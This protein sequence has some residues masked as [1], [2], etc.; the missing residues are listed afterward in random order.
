MTLRTMVAVFIG[1]ALCLQPSAGAGKETVLFPFD[2]YSVPFSKGL[3]LE[4]VPG[5]KSAVNTGHGTDPLHPSKPVVPPG[6]PG[7]PDHPRVYYYGTVL[8]IDGE[9]RMWYS[10]WDKDRKRQVLYAVSRDGVRWDKPDLGLV[11]YN[12]NRRNN[13]V[14]SNGEGPMQGVFV[15]VLHEP[16][17]PDPGRRFKMVREEHPRAIMAAYSPDGLSWTDS[18]NNPIIKGS[19]M[20]T[21]GL[22][23]FNGFY[24]LNGQGGP[25]P[26][27]VPKARGRKMVTYIS[28]DFDHWSEAAHL[29][30]RRNPLPPRP[31]DN[32]EIHRGAQVHM[33]ASLWNRGNVIIG[34]YGQYDNQTND[35]RYSTCDLGLVVSP[36]AIHFK[37]PIPDF[38]ILPSYEEPD[39]AEP[40]LLQGQGFENI[41][42]RTLFWYSIWVAFNPE[43][44]SGVRLATWGRD[45]LGYFAAAPRTE[46]AHFLSTSIKLDSPQAEIY[47]NA[48]GLSEKSQLR[49]EVLD[50]RL[51]PLPGYSGDASI[52]VREPGLRQRVTWRGK[53]QLAGVDGPIRVRVNWE[54]I[55]PEDARLY[56]VY[57]VGSE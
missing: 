17:D 37:E 23:R 43:G 38:K 24:Y 18:P 22:I 1:F 35:R 27:P 19:G 44:P 7:D 47:V 41:G 46:G 33:G 12:G 3:L 4:L 20:E 52:P 39:G 57:V 14:L 21:G 50:H 56:A 40:R 51:R 55:Y 9:Y 13:L 10:G 32:F 26:H 31:L 15:L 48:S 11:E 8:K 42:D 45:R 28:H 5:K 6:K 2:D 34:F 30:F 16:D 53:D 36:D 49:V 25:I 29:S 54:G